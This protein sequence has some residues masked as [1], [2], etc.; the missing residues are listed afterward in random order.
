VPLRRQEDWP[1]AEAA[2]AADP[3]RAASVSLVRGINCRTAGQFA[4]NGGA[5]PGRPHRRHR[6]AGE[7][8]TIY[9][10]PGAGT[11]RI[12]GGAGAAGSTCAGYRRTHAAAFPGADPVHNVNTR[13]PC[14]GRHR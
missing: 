4:P 11:A 3:A 1:Q 12:R 8:I 9:P 13:Q 5:V 2:I 10:I 14:P 7:G 6:D